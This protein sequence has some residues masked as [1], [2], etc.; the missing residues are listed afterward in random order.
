MDLQAIQARV[1]A[2]RDV[3]ATIA[4][5]WTWQEK[6]VAQW[7]SELA[8]FT[9]H[10][11]S[12]SAY[13]QAE[14]DIRTQRNEGYKAL[15]RRTMQ[16]LALLRVSARGNAAH[17][18]LLAKLPGTPKGRPQV[19]ACRTLEAQTSA[20]K[21]AWRNAAEALSEFAAERDDD[22]KAWYALATRLFAAGTATGDLIR[23]RI[24][25]VYRRQPSTPLPPT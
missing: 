14:H 13:E 22:A 9:Q 5:E 16:S 21:V 17:T 6:S 24:P 11:Q 23:G 12:E 3:Q 1:Q 2:T 10:F 20:A 4:Q 8:Q 7:D 25:T 19:L 15:E 18:E